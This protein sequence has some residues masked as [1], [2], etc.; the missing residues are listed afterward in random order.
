MLLAIIKSSI[1]L[2]PGYMWV[3]LYLSGR[4]RVIFHDLF[5]FVQVLCVSW[6]APHIQQSITESGN[7]SDVRRCKEGKLLT[8]TI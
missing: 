8:R 2:D 5:R 6:N 4:N 1:D 3:E 7:R